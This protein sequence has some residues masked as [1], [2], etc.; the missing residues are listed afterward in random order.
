MVVEGLHRLARCS[1]WGAHDSRVENERPPGD[2]MRRGRRARPTTEELGVHI[3]VWCALVI[4]DLVLGLLAVGLRARV[5]R[6]SRGAERGRVRVCMREHSRG[7]RSWA[8]RRCGVL[9]VQRQDR[10]S[11]AIEREDVCCSVNCSR[12]LS[13]VGCS[14]PSQTPPLVGGPRQRPVE[15]GNP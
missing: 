11:I 14:R 1:T 4:E 7:R 8:W 6:I 3:P 5:E 9:A 12:A 15:W 2:E 13:L 10:R